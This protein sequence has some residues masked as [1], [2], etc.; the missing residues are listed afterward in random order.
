MKKKVFFLIN[1]FEMGGAERVL[2]EIVP[3]LNQDYDVKI[4]ALKSNAS[5]YKMNLKP[6]YLSNI[7]KDFMLLPL[8]PYLLFK[9]GRI[10]KKER[11]EKVISFLEISNFI[12]IMTNDEPIISMRTN[13]NFFSGFKGLLY[14]LLI[15]RLYPKSKFIVVNSN[16]NKEDIINLLKIDKNKVKTIYNPLNFDKIMKLKEEPVE[17]EFS[18]LIKGKKAFISAGRLVEGKGWMTLVNCFK[19]FMKINKNAVLVIIGDGPLR[20]T[21]KKEIKMQNMQNNIFLIG[22]KQNVFKYFSRCDCFIYA[23]RA[24]GFPNVMLEA[25]SVNLPI[26]TSDFK[27]GA[28]ELIDPSLYFNKKIK[29]P[30]F[31]PN[32]VLVDS[33]NFGKSFLEM[34]KN[35]I[36]LKQNK[37]GIERFGIKK[38]VKEWEELIET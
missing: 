10:L 20:D 7:K 17:K 1:S 35:E 27:T 16:E 37:A 14:K 19:D 21:I 31:G 28:R 38:I 8:F 15:K 33:H 18:D 23:S 4:Y 36:R 30:Y 13:W 32:G 3:Y 9:F 12:N 22:A 34:F 24:E 11:P 25:M 5:F 29:F 2:S 26:I 6:I